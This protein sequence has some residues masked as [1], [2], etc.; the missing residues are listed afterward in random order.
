MDWM[1]DQFVDW[2]THALLAALDTLASV[3]GST[4][5]LVPNVT[6]VAQ[7]RDL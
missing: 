5:L 4:T 2:F 3:M 7:V 6:T 1:M